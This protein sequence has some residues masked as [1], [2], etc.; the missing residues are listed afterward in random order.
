MTCS[1]NSKGTPAAAQQDDS[2]NVVGFPSQLERDIR[3]LWRREAQIRA[4]AARAR[5]LGEMQAL[6]EERELIIPWLLKY[7]QFNPDPAPA[8]MSDAEI[9]KIVA[10]V[11]AATGK[12][13][14]RVTTTT[15]VLRREDSVARQPDTYPDDLP[16][17][18]EA[19]KYPLMSQAA[20]TALV[21]DIKENGLNED[22]ETLDDGDGPLILDG[23]N[24]QNACREAGVKPRFR[25]LS[26]NTDP[27]AHLISKNLMRRHQTRLELAI[28]A[29]RMV[30]AEHGGDRKSKSTRQLGGLITVIEAARRIGVS[31]RDVERASFILAHSVPELIT[32]IDSGIGWL[33][34]GYA[35][36]LAHSSQDDQRAWL[37][38]K[39]HM[40]KPT[41]QTARL[42]QVP[43][44]W[45]KGQLKN[46][47]DEQRAVI[48]EEVAPGA[49]R[50]LSAER[51]IAIA[52]KI[53][54]RHG[55]FKGLTNQEPH[56]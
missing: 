29:A 35:D 36:K 23:R 16:F 13:I 37:R 42:P 52:D 17:H 45:T 19:E 48:F 33:T 4:Q 30:T 54:T 27:V 24:R 43:I 41:K 32:A 40:I 11:E 22:I 14:V 18:P 34:P 6:Y 53:Y 28:Y 49:I 9:A 5:T 25:A 7:P 10:E 51:A 39:K 31:Q 47:K 3:A 8:P 20:F 46:L 38:D 44:P 1:P 15:D 55:M 50:V 21:D 56:Q 12:K 26:E 2:N